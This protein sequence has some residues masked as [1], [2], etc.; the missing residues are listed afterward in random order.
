ML[1]DVVGVGPRGDVDMFATV[2]FFAAATVYGAL[3]A[4]L[5]GALAAAA[6][7]AP[8]ASG[9]VREVRD[10][11]GWQVHIDTRLL[12][13]KPAATEKA[14]LLLDGQL[15]ELAEV[16]PKAAVARLRQVP[17]YFSPR[18]PNAGP[19]AEYHPGAGWLRDNGRDPV[20]A[21]AVEFTNI[22]DFEAEC[23]RMPALVLHELAHAYHDLTLPDGHGNPTVKAAYERAVASGRYDRVERRDS[24]GNVR[25][26]RAY[27]MTNPAEYFAETSEAFFST[28]DFFPFD[29]QQLQAVDP[30]GC[31]M[32]ATLWGVDTDE[33][34][35]DAAQTTGGADASGRRLITV[36]PADPWF[37]HRDFPHLPTPAWVNE[38]GVEAVI[39]LAIDDMRDPAKYEAALRPIIDRL[40][41]LD[42]RAGVSIMTN[43]VP[44]DDPL[45]ARWLSEGVSLECHT[46][47]HPC[48]LLKDGDFEAARA[49]YETCVDAM[50]TIPANTPVAFRM[51]CCDSLNTVSPRFF[52][53]I[54]RGQTG[55]GRFLEIDS[56]VF[57]AFTADD[58]TLPRELVLDADGQERFLK[59]VP[60]G[61]RY[62]GQEH[63]HFVNLIR[64]YPYPYVI[65]GS[66]WEIPC[67]VPSDWSAQHLH[68]ENNQQTVDDW[69]AAVDLTVA[70][71]GCV[72]LVFHPHGWIRPEQI[73]ELIDHAV[74]THGRK[75]RFLSFRDVAERLQAAYTGGKPLREQAP[76][77]L[78]DWERQR[79]EDDPFDGWSESD[80]QRLRQAWETPEAFGMPPRRRAD[81]SHNGGF[82]RD[83]HFCFANEDTAIRPDFLIR[84][85]F[86]EVLARVE[87]REAAENRPLVGIG[88]A[89]VDITPSFPTRLTGYAARNEDATGVAAP[90]HVRALAIGPASA[91]TAMMVSVDNCGIPATLAERV[92]ERLAAEVT[93]PRERFAILATHTHSAPWLRDFAP[94]IFP[95][96]PAEAAERLARYEEELEEKL[97][98]VCLEA[99]AVQRPGRLS[100]AHGEVGFA[101]NRRA[102]QEGRWTGFGQNAEGPVDHRLPLL[103]AHDADGG[104]IAVVANYACHCTTEPGSFN[105]VSGDW[106]GCAADM[107]EAGHAGAVALMAIGCGADA[108]PSPGGTHELSRA[109]GRE[110]AAEVNRLLE[111]PTAWT[112]LDPEIACRIQHIDLP[113][114]HLPSREEWEAA[115][116]GG[117]V[118]GSRAR[119]FLDML[120]RGEDVPTV[121]P[122]YPVQSWCFGEDLAMVFLAGEVVVDYQRRLD[123]MF[124]RDRLW[125][126]AY[127][128]DVPCYIASARL[129]REGGYEVDSSMLYYR[130]PTRLAPEAE[131]LICDAVQ[132]QLPHAFYSEQLRESFPGPVEPAAAAAAMVPR[133]GMK[134][135]LAAAEPLIRDPVAFDWDEQG[136]LYVVEMADYPIAEGGRTGRVRRLTDTDQDGVYDE[137]VTFLDALPYPTGIQCWRSGVIV[138]MA[139]EVLYA[140][141]TDGDGAADVREPVLEGFSEGNQQHR[142]NGLRMGLD[143]SLLLANGDS[144]GEVRATGYVPGGTRREPSEPLNLR[145]RDL[146]YRP[147]TA[148]IELVAGSSQFGRNRDDFGTWFGNNNSNP[149]WQYAIDDRYLSRNPHA[150]GISAVRQVAAV[151]GAAPVFPLSR[152]LARFN[153]FHMANRF[154]SACGTIVYRDQRLGAGFSGNAFVSEPVHN[155]VSRLVLETSDDGLGFV[156]QRAADETE[157]E[158]LASPDNWFRPT[159]L[160]TGPDGAIWV[161]DMYRNVIEHPEWIPAEYQRK[162]DL[163]AGSDRGRIYRVV[164]DDGCCEAAPTPMRAFFTVPWEAIPLLDVVA[165]LESPNGW[166]RDTAE[167]ILL[168]RR[169]DV[170]ASEAARGEIARLVAAGGAVGVQ[171]LATLEALVVTKAREDDALV[172]FEELDAAVATALA[173]EDGRLRRAGVQAAESAI[174]R[175][176]GDVLAAVGGLGEDPDPRVRQQVLLSLGAA[177][178]TAA[179]GE[180]ARAL[181]A[182]AEVSDL[183]RA[184][185]TSLTP[186]NVDAVVLAVCDATAGGG[187]APLVLVGELLAQANAMG[188]GTALSEPLALLLE[189]TGPDAT[190]ERLRL[191]ADVLQ[192][193]ERTPRVQAAADQ[194]VTVAWQVLRD[195]DASEDRRVAALSLLDAAGESLVSEELTDLLLAP[196]VGPGLQQATLGVMAGRGSAEVVDRIVQRLA[197]LSPQV[198]RR[199]FDGLLARPAAAEWLLDCLADGRLTVADL[200]ASHRDRLLAHPQEAIAARAASLLAVGAG[201]TRGS[202]VDDWLTKVVA[203]TPESAAGGVV[204]EKRCSACHRLQDVGRDV[205]P[206]L[207]ALTDRSTA[208]LVAAILDPNRAV[209]AKYLS[210]TLLTTSGQLQAGLLAEETG[211]GVTLATS[212]GTRVDVPRAEIESLVCSQRSLMPEGLEQDLTPQSLADLIAFVQSAGVAWKP[213]AGNAPAVVNAS[214]DGSL[215]LPASAAEIYGPNLIFEPHYGNLGWWATTADYARWTVNVPRGGDWIVEV[216][217]ACDDSTAGGVMRFS[218]GTRML[219]ARV[220]GT[221]SWDN[222]QTWRAGTLDLGGGRQQITVT[223]VEQSRSALI[224]IRAIRLLPPE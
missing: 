105:E 208:A 148:S 135:V 83:Q 1:D 12:T 142:V 171:A 57:M 4:V 72:S 204:F 123:G 80:Q 184:G 24:E 73:V 122:H 174:A 138:A 62:G 108:N 15:A 113:L 101:V 182:S 10:V 157:R 209:E 194:A 99:I 77:F 21:K 163:A 168:H 38:E 111:T 140:E 121:V 139:P 23:R 45:L 74:E 5:G 159:M 18:Y 170:L 91:P 33:Q 181:V 54:F 172:A 191:A 205:G 162:M 141:D 41:Q 44:A 219:T 201:G 197:G 145:G 81:G 206:D 133:P 34:T 39:V 116:A 93:L 104:L 26:D 95:E 178:G 198:R 222:Y 52:A 186:E 88:A 213:F 134:V 195:T 102:L 136:R 119:Y 48:P 173:S 165:R 13:E 151:P 60:T 124:D 14:L 155:L 17:L 68:G 58:P 220:P 47:T 49:T 66:C 7:Q 8:T 9:V 115:V 127:A 92:Y 70:K 27:A 129:L 36:D 118:A 65:N 193:G 200:E 6:E 50:A 61:H 32:L 185:M 100:L 96:L 46:A 110:L 98:A 169:D 43:D 87:R 215:T 53:E 137:A 131:D 31:T 35:R 175:G 183:R 128:N 152:T 216:D 75:V 203:L 67:L 218:T 143:G 202:L 156:G 180:L 149:I 167:R 150:G 117:G 90:L 86:A 189:G 29:R 22:D 20:M 94:N 223:A 199:F 82:I 146:C 130:K 51:P 217:F 30:A 84:V 177:Q 210:Y 164:P 153:D 63:N 64:D 132:K 160:R 126:N 97:V 179:A 214:D 190:A 78:A 89:V 71:Q 166:W 161:A 207:A 79:A 211:A 69:K 28:N 114:G 40:K 56:S 11:G 196:Q 192:R 224:D 107:L 188:S 187:D 212:E 103:A 76:A 109:H 158:F 147:D 176:D 19:R 112:P 120:D 59:Y 85:P 154:T 42:G 3:G 55:A 106:A 221:G 144:S 2:R 25:L 37:P 125:V 16:V